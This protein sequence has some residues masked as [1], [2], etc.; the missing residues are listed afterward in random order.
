MTYLNNFLSITIL[1]F[2]FYAPVQLVAQ[3]MPG[4]YYV[5]GAEYTESI[6]P[7]KI[8]G[9][10]NDIILVHFDDSHEISKL[11]LNMNKQKIESKSIAQLAYLGPEFWGLDKEKQVEQLAQIMQNSQDILAPPPQNWVQWTA[12]AYVI[13]A[14]IVTL[15]ITLPM[16]LG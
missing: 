14:F 10:F 15:C 16:Q 9:Y 7:D 5:L 6:D 11:N 3:G 2:G 4:N 8:Y 13:W 12:E 1:S